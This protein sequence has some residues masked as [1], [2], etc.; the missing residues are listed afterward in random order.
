LNCSLADLEL[1]GQRAVA[2]GDT[3]QLDD[4]PHTLPFVERRVDLNRR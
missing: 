4:E 1:P 3:P 2:R